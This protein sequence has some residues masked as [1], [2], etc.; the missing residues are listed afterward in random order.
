MDEGILY[1]KLEQWEPLQT[2]QNKLCQESF[3]A[4]CTIQKRITARKNECTTA[5]QHFCFFSINNVECSLA[6]LWEIQKL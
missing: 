6:C 5:L 2:K 3:R 1:W 4:K